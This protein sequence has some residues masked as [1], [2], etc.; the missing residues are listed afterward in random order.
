MASFL[1]YFEGVRKRTLSFVQ[2]IPSDQ[3]DF[4]PYP[5]RFTFGDLVRHL[6]SVEAMYAR[7]ILG[8]DWTYEGHGPEHG[9]NLSP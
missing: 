4:T 6:G 1:K 5:G 3:V 8:A 7:T 9:A 2:R